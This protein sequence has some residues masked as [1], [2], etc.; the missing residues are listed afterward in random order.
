MCN[1]ILWFFL[2][3]WSQWIGLLNYEISKF[4]TSSNISLESR[5][6]GHNFR[7]NPLKFSP[8][9]RLQWKF[10]LL[11][12]KFTWGNKAKHCWVISTNFLFS[13]VADKT[14]QC[15]AFTPQ[16]NFPPRFEFSL[17]VKAMGLNPGY[18]L[19]QYFLLYKLEVHIDI[20]EGYP[21]H[22]V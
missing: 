14:Q 17:F 22:V 11:A 10:K 3:G 1:D 9:L 19:L 2:I 7:L 13:K 4:I 16:A 6:F 18:L 20:R 5:L 8:Q 12:E 15:F 21:P